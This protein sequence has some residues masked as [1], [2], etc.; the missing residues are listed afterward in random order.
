MA[1]NS[2]DKAVCKVIRHQCMIQVERSGSKETIWDFHVWIIFLKWIIN[3]MWTILLETKF[4]IIV[5]YVFSSFTHHSG[6]KSLD[7]LGMW[8]EDMAWFVHYCLVLAFNR[9]LFKTAVIERM[10]KYM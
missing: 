3:Q 10:S 5:V 4:T 2:V 1:R 6:I 9:W 7:F 8:K